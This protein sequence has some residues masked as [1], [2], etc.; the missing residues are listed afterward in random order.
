VSLGGILDQKERKEEGQGIT[1]WEFP[2]RSMTC[3]PAEVDTEKAKAEFKKGVLTVTLPKT[4]KA[5]KETKKIPV[6]AE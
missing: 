2:V 1:G 3:L 4:A 5:I 6:K